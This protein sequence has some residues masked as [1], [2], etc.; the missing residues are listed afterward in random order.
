MNDKTQ[1]AFYVATDGNDDWSGT[2]PAPN[3]AGT[4]GPFATLARARDA[5]RALK[6]E[7]P[8]LPAQ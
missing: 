3:E 4:D 1:L 8:A 6:Q 7:G 5:I 2:L